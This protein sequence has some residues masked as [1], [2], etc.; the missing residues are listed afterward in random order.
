MS[1]ESIT[2]QV[3]SFVLGAGTARTVLCFDRLPSKPIAPASLYSQGEGRRE[4]LELH[5]VAKIRGKRVVFETFQ[6]AGAALQPK[7]MYRFETWWFAPWLDV[8]MDAA[9]VWRRETF[10][11]SD[12]AVYQTGKA[13]MTRRA[14]EADR[15]RGVEIE[16]GGWEHEHC[17]VCMAKISQLEPYAHVGYT[18]GSDW[19]CTQ[20]YERFIASGLG[21]KLR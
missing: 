15:A 3:V 13:V 4:V 11:T 18:D 1:K 12:S 8:V 17:R 5:R 20:C 7:E 6:V 21:P 2:A 9:K 19:L 16:P 14:A 10:T